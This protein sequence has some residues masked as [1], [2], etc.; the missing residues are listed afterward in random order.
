MKLFSIFMSNCAFIKRKYQMERSL[1]TFLCSVTVS[2]LLIETMKG[3]VL[4]H[5][6]EPHQN[7]NKSAK[8]M[9]FFHGNFYMVGTGIEK[10]T[11]F[12]LK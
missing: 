7:P 6:E 8:K 4:C 2:L 10:W 12:W 1:N 5:R 3:V 11:H 9:L